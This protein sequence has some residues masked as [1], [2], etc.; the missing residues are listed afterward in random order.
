[1]KPFVAVNDGMVL[2]LS[3]RGSIINKSIS[4]R[5]FLFKDQKYKEGF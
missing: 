2:F 1:M 5:N 4:T 3:K